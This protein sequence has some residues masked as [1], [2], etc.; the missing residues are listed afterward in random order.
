MFGDSFLRRDNSAL[1]GLKHFDDGEQ[2]AIMKNSSA[3]R[4]FRS[5]PRMFEGLDDSPT[6]Y[7]S[8]PKTDNTSRTHTGFP[9]SNQKI[10]R[11]SRIS[12]PLVKSLFIDE[13]S[14]DSG[15]FA[16]DEESPIKMMDLS[17][18][19]ILDD[20]LDTMMYSSP[21]TSYSK[22]TSRQKPRKNL[23]NTATVTPSRGENSPFL[24]MFST[25][26]VKRRRQDD[27]QSGDRPQ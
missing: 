8:F 1:D 10:S 20:S 24:K 5:M 18:D 19:S 14:K 13:N 22:K 23:F 16:F 26:S 7:K 17:D 15:I 9:P 27:T 2:N 25:S 6:E 12:S 4:H 21:I 3:F 11:L